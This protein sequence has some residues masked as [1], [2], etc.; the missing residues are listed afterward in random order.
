MEAVIDSL[1]GTGVEKSIKL[2]RFAN[3]LKQTHNNG[4]KD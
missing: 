1:A 2:C 4:A 3:Y